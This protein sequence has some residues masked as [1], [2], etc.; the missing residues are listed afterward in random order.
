MWS[1]NGSP[2]AITPRAPSSTTLAWHSTEPRQTT[3]VPTMCAPCRSIFGNFRVG[4]WPHTKGAQC[5]VI[6]SNVV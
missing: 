1:R 4:V 6:D 5:P 3:L 2:L